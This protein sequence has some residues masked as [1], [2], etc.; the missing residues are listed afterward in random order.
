MG[1]WDTYS[2]APHQYIRQNGEEE[3]EAGDAGAAEDAG[4]AGG[5]TEWRWV[6]W[7]QWDWESQQQCTGHSTNTGLARHTD[8]AA[9]S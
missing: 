2:I 9:Y 5:K 4:G 6:Q 3:E 7:Q 8:T 1:W